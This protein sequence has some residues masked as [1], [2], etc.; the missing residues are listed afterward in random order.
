MLLSSDLQEDD[1]EEVEAGEQPGVEMK[2]RWRN[3]VSIIQFAVT[4]DSFGFSQ[5]EDEGMSI[6]MK[7]S[8]RNKVS[9]MLIIMM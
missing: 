6:K 4:A 8:R 1:E 3:N 5:V 7:I 9:A 2:M